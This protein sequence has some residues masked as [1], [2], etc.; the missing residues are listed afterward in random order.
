[1]IWH[2]G[3]WTVTLWTAGR[4]PSF[5]AFGARRVDASLLGRL[6]LDQWGGMPS[7]FP[8]LVIDEFAILPD[9]FR[10]LVHAPGARR[11]E[12]AVLW[13]KAAVS[14]QARIASLSHRSHLWET[15]AELQPV[16]EASE[17]ASWRRRI[18]TGRALGL[19]G[20]L[21]DYR[22]A[23]NGTSTDIP[24][25]AMVTVGNT[26]RASSINSGASRL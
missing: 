18:R 13:F 4:V 22:A 9:R 3:I 19:S 14:R 6:V 25:R 7:R 10:A 26:A 15:G 1:M 8:D 24:S 2:S 23:G 11:L 20:R 16:A 5:V 17:L 12:R 21:P